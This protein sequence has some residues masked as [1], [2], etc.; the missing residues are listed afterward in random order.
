MTIDLF[1]STLKTKKEQVYDFIRS[2]SPVRT[3]QVI[4]FASS[5]FCNRGDRYARDLAQEGKIKRMED[6]RKV[7]LFGKT[8]EEIWEIC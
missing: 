3:S 2:N 8:A 4:R 5:I 6:W 7:A 1:P